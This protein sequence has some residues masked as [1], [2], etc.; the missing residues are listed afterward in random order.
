[1]LR[2]VVD[3]ELL[4]VD[5]IT[6]SEFISSL[7]SPS[8][9]YTFSMKPLEGHCVADFSPALAFAFVDRMFGGRGRALN[10]EREMTGIELNVMDKIARR[11]Y[12][13][14]TEGWARVAEFE[15]VQEAVETTPQFIQIVPPGETVIVT[16]LQLTM[17]EVTGVLTL[18]YPYLTIEPLMSRISGQSWSDAN[19]ARGTDHDRQLI[20]ESLRVVETEVSAV[21]AETSISMSDFLAINVGD[22]LLTESETPAPARLFVGG[23]EKF[24]ARPGMRGRRRALEILAPVESAG[25]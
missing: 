1:M 24:T 25:A 8:C 20:R 11:V 14:L 2:A 19:K 5:Q 21:L 15:I 6:Y 12:R 17:L 9:I 10:A 3:I 16:A 13:E 23:V 18:C 22:V 7:S 4:S